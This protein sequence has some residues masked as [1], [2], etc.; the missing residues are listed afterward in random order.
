MGQKRTKTFSQQSHKTK[1]YIYITKNG[2]N[3]PKLMRENLY[4]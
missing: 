4:G 1:K 3:E 2:L